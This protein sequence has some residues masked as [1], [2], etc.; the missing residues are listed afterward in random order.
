ML[1]VCPTGGSDGSVVWFDGGGG[2]GT[3]SG[4][5]VVVDDRDS[6]PDILNLYIL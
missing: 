1:R 2:G 3:N 4:N 6:G 5:G